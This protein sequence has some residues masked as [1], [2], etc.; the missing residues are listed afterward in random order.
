MRLVTNERR[1]TIDRTF[2]FYTTSRCY[3][4]IK[5]TSFLRFFVVFIYFIIPLNDSKTFNL[6]RYVILYYLN[7]R[8]LKF[9]CSCDRKFMAMWFFA[10]R[11]CVIEETKKNYYFI[12]EKG[13][14]QVLNKYNKI[15]L[16]CFVC[17]WWEIETYRCS[18]YVQGLIV[19]WS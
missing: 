17:L 18:K 5:R 8:G 4:F 2:N 10:V 14:F 7:R 11:I 19:C 3:C 9:Y 15:S 16:W 1:N 6:L 12:N 13:F